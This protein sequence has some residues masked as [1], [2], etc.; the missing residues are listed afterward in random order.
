MITLDASAL[1][2]HFNAHG[3]HHHQVD[4]LL[5]N[6]RRGVA[7]TNAVT[8]KTSGP[9]PLRRTTTLATVQHT[10]GQ[11]DIERSGAAAVAI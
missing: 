6:G 8:I 2:A 9:F 10:R 7:S 4:Q 11:D 1:I 5:F 3:V